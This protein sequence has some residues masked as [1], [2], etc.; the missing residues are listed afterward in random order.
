MWS[1]DFVLNKDAYGGKIRM[2]TLIDK[3]G[4]KC[5]TI[6]CARRIGSAQVI[7]QLANTMIANGITEF[8]RSNN[9]QSSLT[10]SYAVGYVALA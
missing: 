5:L 1:Y 3:F 10:K 9:G 7:E 8:I 4:R 6:Y 2:L